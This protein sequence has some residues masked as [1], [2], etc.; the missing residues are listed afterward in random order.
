MA[1][2]R[3]PD[4]VVA[5]IGGLTVLRDPLRPSGRLLRQDDMD[6]SY[7]DLA[8]PQ[9]L[10][11]DY[12]RWARIVLEAVSARRV[13]HVG[14]AGCALARALAAGDPGGRHEV[15]EVDPVVLEVAR[16]HL[17]LRRAPGL[18]VRVGDGRERI[19]Q[20]ADGSA[21]AIVLDAFV[22][23]R[24]PRHLVT[25]E[26]FADTARVA[27][28][29]LV[30]IVDTRSLTDTRTIAAALMTAYPVAVALGARGLRGG[31]V[32]LAGSAGP[33]PLDR[34]GARAAADQSPARLTAPDDLARLVG[35][36]VPPRDAEPS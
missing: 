36:Q 29:T 16:E 14:G 25:V 28:L 35:G 31:N 13:L 34:I 7:V 6:A 18:R 12:L 20:R 3:A 10:D 30:N 1:R 2:R 32:V 4:P 8:D 27:P 21:D 33:L 19:A 5:Q 9:H 26:A 15:V 17:G 23:A 11:F 22:G 24:V